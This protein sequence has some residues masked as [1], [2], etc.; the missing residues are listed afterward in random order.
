MATNYPHYPISPRK[1][2]KGNDVWSSASPLNEGRA[3]FEMYRRGM[4]ADAI[5]DLIRV[6]EKERVELQEFARE[7][8]ALA[9][10]IETCVRYRGEV[11][12]VFDRLVRRLNSKEKAA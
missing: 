12:E 9:K 1:P 8:P 4:D 10:R 7:N 2:T 3:L 5:R 6:T 11:E